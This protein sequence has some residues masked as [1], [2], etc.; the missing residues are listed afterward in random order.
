MALW[1]VDLSRC[2][3]EL[4]EMLEAEST[5]PDG[6]GRVLTGVQGNLGSSR[7]PAAATDFSGTQ[8]IK[9]LKWLAPGSR[10]AALAVKSR[11]KGGFGYVI[12]FHANFQ[13][14]CALTGPCQPPTGGESRAS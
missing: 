1:H 11:R 13:E 6:F 2:S 5:T 7:F 8:R 3:N 4:C 14:A 10:L 9:Q 12:D